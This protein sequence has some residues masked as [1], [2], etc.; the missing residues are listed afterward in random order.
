MI[1]KQRRVIEQAANYIHRRRRRRF[2]ARAVAVMAAVYIPLCVL[3]RC[4]SREEL[5]LFGRLKNNDKTTVKK[6]QGI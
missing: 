4:F 6:Y 1:V 3:L 2:W 5:G